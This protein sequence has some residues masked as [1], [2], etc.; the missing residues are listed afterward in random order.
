MQYVI[1]KVFISSFWKM[2]L[3]MVEMNRFF[4]N[5]AWKSKYEK[6]KIVT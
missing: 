4:K 6:R 3:M 1:W 5:E 2:M